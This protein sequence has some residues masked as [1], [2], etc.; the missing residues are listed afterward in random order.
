MAK[1]QSFGVYLEALGKRSLRNGKYL[2]RE[3]IREIGAM[4]LKSKILGKR[5]SRAF[6]YEGLAKKFEE[7][8]LTPTLEEG[9]DLVRRIHLEE[10]NC[11]SKG[12]IF[13]EEV[14]RDRILMGY[15]PNE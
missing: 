2:T 4:D 9:R 13:F 11:G 7:I 14:N 12:Y 3:N 5:N 8:K 15:F 6:F 10:A 1:M